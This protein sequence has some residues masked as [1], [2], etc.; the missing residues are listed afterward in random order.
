MYPEKILLAKHVSTGWMVSVR[1]MIENDFR[2]AHCYVGQCGKKAKSR[3][4]TVLVPSLR[5]G[6]LH[7]FDSHVCDAVSFHFFHDEFL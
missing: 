1:H 5:C 3:Q 7:V 4:Q 6:R 2:D